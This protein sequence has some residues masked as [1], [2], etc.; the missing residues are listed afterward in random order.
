MQLGVAL[1]EGLVH[2]GRHELGHIPAERGDLLARASMKA[3]DLLGQNPEGFF[4]MVEGGKIDWSCHSN[5]PATTFE[6]VIDMDNAIKVNTSA[7]LKAINQSDLLSTEDKSS[8]A[9]FIDVDG[10][11]L[12]VADDNVDCKVDVEGN[13]AINY[14]IK[15]KAPNFKSAIANI[16][17]DSVYISPVTND[18]SEELVGLMMWTDNM[19]ILVAGADQ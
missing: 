5:D 15:M 2:T 8:K 11:V 4:L 14:N 17:S 9:L 3:I 6:E 1:D 10:S 7:I 16:D 18:E 19:S 12:T 13:P